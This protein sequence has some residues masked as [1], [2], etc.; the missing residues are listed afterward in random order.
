MPAPLD[1]P[2]TE[3]W[4]RVLAATLPRDDQERYERHLESCPACRERL[5]RL[6]PPQADWLQQAR[7][8]GD[9]T[10][11]P[12]EPTLVQVL[13][14]LLEGKSG[15]RPAP[16]EPA[17]LGFL[18]PPDRPG[19]LGLLGEY[20]VQGVIGQ[21]GMGIVLKAFEPALHRL[22]AIKVMAPVL[23]GSATARRRF[24][25]EAQAAAAVCHDHVVAVHG[26]REVDGLPYLVMQYVAGESLQARLDRTG[27]LEA[28][29]TVR[30]GLQAASGLAAAH[31]QG[32]IHRDVKP[33]NLLLEDGLARVKVSDFGLART[34]DDVGLTQTG[35][36]AGT[37]EYMAP[38]QARGEAVDHRADLFSLGSVLYACCT[39]LPPFRGPT[40]LAV[41]HRVNDQEPTPVRSLNPQVPAWLEAVILRLLAKDPADRFQSAAEVAALLQGY[42]AHLQQPATV[43]AP[44]L[45]PPPRDGFREPSGP[46]RRRLW[47]LALLLLPVLGLGIAFLF[48]GAAAEKGPGTEQAQEYYLPLRG[49]PPDGQTWEFI[50]P[51]ADQCVKFEPDGLRITLPRDYP[52]RRPKTGVGHPLTVKGDFEMTVSYEILQEPDQAD[53]G[54]ATPFF[55]QAVQD[56]ARETGPGITRRMVTDDGPQFAAWAFVWDADLGKRRQM[57]KPFPAAGAKTGRLRMTRRG[58]AVSY[59]VAEGAATDFTLLHELPVTEEDVTE[60]QFAGYTGG[61]TAALDVRFTDLRIRSGPN[62]STAPGQRAG[63]KGWLAGAALLVLVLTLAF[64]FWLHLRQRRRAG[65]GPPGQQA[66]PA[67]A[68]PPV[69]FPC[70]ACG[71][72]LKVRAELAGKKVKCPHCGKGTLV[73]ETQPGASPPAAVGERP[74]P[75]VGETS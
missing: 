21:G 31:A 16:A 67:A 11:V 27:P 33:A 56:R 54:K 70:A 69:S 72:R 39:G 38:E 14:R 35:V 8:V 3:S 53:A 34:A 41:L 55:L 6:A 61:P 19:L 60:V 45:P 7:Q 66:E 17:D 26:V 51:Q 59:S 50:G 71:T 13:G 75:Q 23:A 74:D 37:P 46:R 12:D 44:E 30:I 4:Q 57:W 20:E 49:E 42:L 52:G 73:P 2:E 36:V 5:E 62:S 48:A 68:A 15:A 32:L 64:G 58:A 24:T 1:C 25:R 63:R 65:T 18:T 43:P 40:P 28:I 10:A 22:V 47:P 9:P 29:D